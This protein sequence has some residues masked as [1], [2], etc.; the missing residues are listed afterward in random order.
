MTREIDRPSG[1]FGARRPRLG[2]FLAVAVLLVTIVVSPSAA[3]VADTTPT[4]TAEAETAETDDASELTESPTSTTVPPTTTAPTVPP[5]TVPSTTV[6][7]TTVLP[8]TVPPTT[9]PPTTVLP[10]TVPPTTVL[11][12]TVPSTTDESMLFTPFAVGDPEYL[13]VSKTVSDSTPVVGEPFT[14][15]IAVTCTEASCLDAQLTDALPTELAGYTVRNVTMTPDATSVPHTV[16]WTENG[17]VTAEPTVIGLATAFAVDFTDAVT[18]P[19]GTGI[20]SGTTFNVTITLEVP[21]D[22]APGTYVIDNTADTTATNSA[23]GTSTASITVEVPVD[24]AIATTK[25]W[26]PGAQSFEPGA[27][28]TIALGATNT[29][30]VGV[31]TLTIQEPSVAPEGAPALDADNPFT[32]VDFDGF[33]AVTLPTGASAVQVDAYVF[34]GVSSSWGWVTGTAGAT[35]TLPAGVDPADVGGLRF[36]Y[37]STAPDTIA[38][39]ATATGALDVV[40]RATERETGEDL[41]TSTHTIDNVAVATAT[42][43]GHD[44]IDAEAGAT[45]QVTPPTLE[46]DAMKDIT[47]GRISAGDSAVGVISARNG[48]DVGAAELRLADLDYFT[49]DITFGGFTSPPAWPSD[50]TEA[51][52][53]Y[54]LLAGGT[55]EVTFTDGASPADPAAPISGFEI[56]FTAPDGGIDGDA[57]TSASFEIVTV[58]GATGAVD[59]LTTTN[60]VVATVTAPNGLSGSDA[61]SDTLT[62]VEPDIEITLDK[63]ILPNAAVRPGESV[64]SSLSANLE[65][66]SD[67]V[68]ATEIVVEDAWNGDAATFWDGF[69]L[70]EIASTQVPADTTLTVEVQTAV[71]TW[72]T[73]ATHADGSGPS[74]FSMA[75]PEMAAALAPTALGAVTGIRFTFDNPSGF[76]AD[77]TVTP[78]VVADARGDLRTGGATT[79]GPDI[80]VNFVNSAIATGAGTTETG[81]VVDDADGDLGEATIVTDDGVGPVG[82]DKQW[83]QATVPAQS[84]ARRTTPIDWR[85]TS[86]YESVTITDPNSIADTA[87]TTFQ[88]FD[89]RALVPVAASSTPYSNGWY[90]RYDTITSVRLYRSGSWVTVDPPAGGWNGPAGGFVGYQLSP[91]ERADTTG[92]ELTLVE[93]TPA[94][95]AAQAAG[96]AYDPYAPL[97]GSGVGA[98]STNRRFVL[99]WQIRD[100]T[101]VGDDWVTSTELYNTPDAG[102][103][104]NVVE[105]AA[106]PSGGGAPVSS[107]DGAT[108]RITDPPPGVTIDKSVVAADPTYVPAPGTMDP[109]S[110]PTATY[111][112]TANNNSV[113]RTSYVRVTDPPSCTDAAPIGSCAGDAT[114]AGATADPFAASIDWLNPTASSANPF[115]RYDLTSV[116]I[117]SSLPVEVD[118][119]ATVVWLLRYDSATETFSSTAT[120]ASAAN[121]LDATAL[122]D[123]VGVSV[124]YQ[125]SDPAADGGSITAD[126]DLTVTMGL[127]LRTTVR[128]SGEPQELL[129][130]ETADVTNRAVAQSY[131][132]ILSGGVV[133]ADLADVHH[134][135]TGGVLNVAPSKSVSP[136]TL[137]EPD[138]DLPVSVELGADQG[139]DP[140]STLSP[141]EVWLRDDIV[142]SPDFWNHFDVTGLGTIDGPN[143]ADEVTV[144]VRGPYGPGGATTWIDDGP[145]PIAAAAIPAAAAADMSQIDG[146]EFRFTRSD[147]AFFSTTLPAPNWSA[148]VVFTARLRETYRAGDEQI[149]FDGDVEVDNTVTV[150]SLRPTE[151]TDERQAIAALEL[152]PGTHELSVGK[153]TNNGNRFGTI[154]S[155]VP[156]DL[157]FENTGTGYLTIDELRDTL[158][159]T[160][161]YLGDPAPVTSPDPDGL[162]PA[163]VTVTQVGQD[164]IFTWPTDD[165]VMAPDEVYEIR[166]WLELQPTGSGEQALNT[167][168]V[169]TQQTLGRCGHVG[170]GDVTDA[171]DDDPTTCATTDYVTPATG[172]NLFA[173]KGVRGAVDGAFVPSNP[174]AVCAPTL[175]ADSGSYYRTPCVANSVVGGTDDWALRA[176]NAGTVAV[177]EMTV[178]DQLPVRDDAF[179]VSGAGRNSEYRPRLVGGSLQIDAPPGTTHLVEVTTSG[180]V[181]IDTWSTLTTQE[182]CEQNGELWTT[183]DGA[184]DWDAVSGLRITFDFSDTA[185]GVLASGQAIDIAYSTV[186]AVET[187][188]DPSGTSAVVPADDEYAWNQFGVKY[189]NEG[190]DTYSKIAPNAVG[191]HLMTGPIRVDKQISGEGAPYAPGAF[192]VDVDCSVDDTPLDLG[193]S[194]VLTL[195][196]T[197]GRSARID[198]IPVGAVCTIAEQGDLGT[199]GES[200]RAV[201][202]SEL[203][204]ATPAEPEDDVPGA[205]ITTIV[206]DYAMTG[207]SVAKRVDTDAVG[208]ELGPFDFTLTCVTLLGEEVDFAGAGTELAFTLGGGATWEAPED[209]IPVGATCT[210]TETDRSSADGTTITGMGVVDHGDGVATIDVGEEPGDVTVA[211]HFGAGELVVEKVVEGEGAERYGAGTFGFTA[212]CTYADQTLL[213]ADFEL[214]ATERRVFGP[215]PVGTDCVIV[216]TADGGATTSELTPSS[217][218]VTITADEATVV[219]AM[220]TFDVT[221]LDVTKIVAGAVPT[222]PIS[223]TVTLECA[224]ERDGVTEPVSIPG[225]PTRRLETSNQL[226]ATYDDLPT[227]AVCTITETD[228]G[229]AESTSIEIAGAQ[230]DSATADLVTPATGDAPA[231][232]VRIVNDFGA[233]VSPPT[234]DPTPGPGGLPATGADVVEL[235]FGAL[236]VVIAGLVLVMM[237]GRLSAL[238][239]GQLRRPRR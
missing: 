38:S 43:A 160:L 205:Q 15:T 135:L 222:G 56:V 26:T 176:M 190:S 146:I 84:G 83:N 172:A 7:S 156:F 171:W 180:G 17:S 5:T 216:E 16:T 129:A 228:R 221:S 109:G 59:E 178:F 225:G 36:T 236:L 123:V 161:L 229:G 145:T 157:T 61:D 14:Y 209:S 108:I 131:D 235:L 46:V 187:D 215:F 102:I 39:G 226:T 142:S 233:D 182:P 66:S 193:S 90:L 44:P 223:F 191:V 23:P 95:E 71:G 168:T 72:L 94:R 96:A 210:L 60:E 50:A 118:L 75:G 20:Q 104:D 63:D 69:E 97:P 144:S 227:G 183:A 194:A 33:G 165:R 113:A 11:P 159:S 140:R 152:T 151:S 155:L 153:L 143:G 25:S 128:S 91:A 22:L 164:V 237:D 174:A 65:T 219:T 98:G 139:A 40:Q 107:I 57:D 134:E 162:L 89:L 19:S 173:V 31:D 81:T 212:T 127:Q 82:V 188:D 112:L 198:G 29:S 207:L 122:A 163:E 8:T 220:N 110:F 203:L 199:Y 132:P 192:D 169:Q 186:N 32:I 52:V 68:S 62:L 224:V 117:G 9:V 73:L 37:T 137:A 87:D 202:V 77:T 103:V 167:M 195:D 184:T 126:N 133:A 141:T 70:T 45:Y 30:N 147:G 166:I 125:A 217:G 105:L 120:T 232:D 239:S 149:T 121:S 101:R 51:T 55:Q 177:S 49:P 64:V 179:L 181:C 196:S 67:Y 28:S 154:G 185:G 201:A 119:D 6:P 100:R 218:R 85:V 189:R 136:T 106:T 208:A 214:G 21:A 35:A 78:Y 213:D 86:G 150:Q 88:A 138:R 116:A 42:V 211:N 34:E 111:T 204:V 41:S 158:P 80:P 130:G 54:H 115:D 206:N 148:S 53:V 13:T 79:P 230:S 1:P 2:A 170:A 99:D 4:E 48:S 92:V 197:N 93:N 175:T 74:M 114:A 76:A 200:G 231:V 10:T 58:E 3:V 238:R 27:A 47:P 24:L 124:T 234:P 18:S 12:T